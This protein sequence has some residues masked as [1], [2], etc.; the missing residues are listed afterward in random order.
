MCQLW[1]HTEDVCY[2]CGYRHWRRHGRRHGHLHRTLL[3][4]LH[5]CFGCFFHRG[6]GA[7]FFGQGLLRS[8]G[9]SRS[10]GEFGL[11]RQPLGW[12]AGG[13][14]FGRRSVVRKLI[15]TVV[16]ARR[17]AACLA[18]LAHTTHPATLFAQAADQRRKVGV[19]GSNHHHVGALGQ[20]QVQRVDGQGDVGGVFA[21]RQI[22]HRFDQQ[23]L[24][25]VLVFHRA[26]G[27]AISAAHMQRTVVRQEQ[28]NGL[29]HHVHR[30]VVGVDQQHHALGTHGCGLTTISNSTFRRRAKV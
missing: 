3:G 18:Q 11:R 17:F 5:G 2:Q 10:R 21:R 1:Q 30:H 15:K 13:P 26:L 23:T 28:G 8:R 24:E 9:R 20:H 14:H 7:R 25:H 22:H 19:R 6:F 27:R 29:L 4:F 16:D 12:C